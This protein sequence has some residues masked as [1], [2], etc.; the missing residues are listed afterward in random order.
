MV[1][2]LLEYDL[3]IRP[4]KLIK[5]QGLAKPMVESNCDL[6]ILHIVVELSTEEKN[7][8]E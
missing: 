6:I 7:P 4:T 8:E 3:D 2:V 5:A 1:E